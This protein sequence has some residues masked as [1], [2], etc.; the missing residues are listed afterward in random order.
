M[1]EML[2]RLS[3][4]VS[5]KTIISTKKVLSAREA[6]AYMN[7]SI[8]SLYKLTMRKQVPHYKPNGKMT[9]F[10]RMELETWLLRNR[11]ATTDEISDKAQA[12]CGKGG[13]L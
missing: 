1:D 9:Y 3:D 11:V 6:A 10:D 2:Q 8:S 7:I 12:Y 13:K 5:Q 4:I